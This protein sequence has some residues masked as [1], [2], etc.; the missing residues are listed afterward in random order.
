MALNWDKYDIEV[1]NDDVINRN[2]IFFDLMQ[3][4]FNSMDGLYLY[5]T[6]LLIDTIIKYNLRKQSVAEIENMNR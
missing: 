4:T 5:E 6:C 3:Q 1:Q 2:Q